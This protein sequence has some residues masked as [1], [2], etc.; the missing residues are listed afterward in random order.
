MSRNRRFLVAGLL[1][2]LFLAGVV[3]FYA[4]SAPDGLMKVA[5]DK[6]IAAKAGN[7]PADDGPLAGYGAKDVGNARLSRGL[8]GFAGVVLT[9]AVGGVVFL[10]LSRGRRTERDAATGPAGT[11]T[12]GTER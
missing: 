6:G 10:A 1:V 7:H 3:S 9:F 2:A 11:R 8:A 12:P 4:S 5:R